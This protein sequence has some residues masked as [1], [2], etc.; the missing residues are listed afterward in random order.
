MPG[1]WIS[2]ELDPDFAGGQRLSAGGVIEARAY[3][4]SGADQGTVLLAL[5]EN[6]KLGD[7]VKAEYIAASDDYYAHWAASQPK[8]ATYHFCRGA[9]QRCRVGGA[10]AHIEA[11]RE[12]A[13][14]DLTDTPDAESSGATASDWSAERMSVDGAS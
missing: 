4:D 11:F 1:P 13:V 7:K 10:L 12:V 9:R 5:T 14:E 6:G 8:Q 3:D 2:A